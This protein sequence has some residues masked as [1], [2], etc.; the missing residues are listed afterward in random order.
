MSLHPIKVVKN[1]RSRNNFF[2]ACCIKNLVIN[3][4]KLRFLRISDLTAPKTPWYKK[5]RKVVRNL[6]SRN[7]FSKACRIKNLITNLVKLRFL[8]ILDLAAPKNLL[9]NFVNLYCLFSIG[10]PELLESDKFYQLSCTKRHPKVEP[11]ASMISIISKLSHKC[12]QGYPILN[13]WCCL[14]CST[15]WRNF[16]GKKICKSI[17]RYP[18]TN[19][20]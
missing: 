12:S 20:Q 7:N 19:A 8:R 16:E 17:I 14:Y 1:L 5:T 18:Q 6:R 3:L 15:S 4:V 2:K 9:T 11:K 10:N 13:L